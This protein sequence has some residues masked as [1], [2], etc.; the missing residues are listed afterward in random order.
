MKRRTVISVLILA[1]VVLMI[2]SCAGCIY[3]PVGDNYKIHGATDDIVSIEIYENIVYEDG[4]G[5]TIGDEIE[6]DVIVPSERYDEFVD[7][8]HS[9]NGFRKYFLLVLGAVDPSFH[10]Y[11]NVVKIT[12]IGGEI[13][14]ISSYSP[15]FYYD[16][17]GNKSMSRYNCD[18]DDW[19]AFLEKYIGN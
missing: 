10:L 5:D 4:D 17:E 15:Q 14:Y 16:A 9:L 12:Y 3:F 7:E 2:V 13:E 8:L 6:P 1:L 18:T 19:D 11:G